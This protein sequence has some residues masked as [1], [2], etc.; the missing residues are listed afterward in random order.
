MPYRRLPNTDQARIRSMQT[1]IEQCRRTNVP[2][3]AFSI[4]TKNETEAFL[5]AFESAHHEYLMCL[6]KQVTA[7]K[8]Y[9]SQIKMARLYIS[10][11]IQVLNFS[12][13]RN[14]IKPE[15]K[16]LY[17]LEPNN[18]TVPD[19]TTELSLLNWGER[20]VA[21]EQERIRSGGA[22]IYNPA[23]AKVRVHFDIFKDGG[24]SQKTFQR[25]TN[26]TLETI[27]TLR[28]TSDSI[29]LDIWNQVE[30]YYKLLPE[31]A[32]RVKC[33]AYGLRYYFRKNEIL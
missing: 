1:A 19:L 23:I 16:H 12:V 7:G 22:P 13:I 11:F 31:S 8:K 25:S 15:L 27:A 20:V 4:K 33:E 17:G 14:E 18:F 6:E 10:H 5:P 30:D 28:K 24:I 29:I 3:L 32:R 21:G 2:D 26:R 9:Q